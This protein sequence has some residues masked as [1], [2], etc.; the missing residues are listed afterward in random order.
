M[1][2]YCNCQI[3]CSPL[4]LSSYWFLT[5]IDAFLALLAFV[6]AAFGASDSLPR[7][8]CFLLLVPE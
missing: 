7:F 6:P 2:D 5:S 1:E 8:V 3:V 4:Y